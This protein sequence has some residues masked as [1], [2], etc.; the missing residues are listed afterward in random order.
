MQ[1]T[2]T[3]GGVD[4]AQDEHAVCVV[5]DTG[6]VITEFTVAHSAEGLDDLCKRLRQAGRDSCRD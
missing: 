3:W 6:A 5:D 4:W 2:T 1:D